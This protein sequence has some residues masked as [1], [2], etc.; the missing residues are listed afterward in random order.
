M[1][2]ELLKEILSNEELI[3]LLGV[4][5]DGNPKRYLLKAPDNTAA[6]YIEYEILNENGSMY[7]ENEELETTYTIQI[8]V[9]TK[10]SYTKIVKII[11]KIMKEK[12]F[13]K[14]VGGSNYEEKSK[15][16]HYVLRFNYESEE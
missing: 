5:K 14:E 8:D 16:F 13:L 1:I 15:L 11:K 7:A 6:P 9:Y 12:G 3:L 4:D 2:E 10:G